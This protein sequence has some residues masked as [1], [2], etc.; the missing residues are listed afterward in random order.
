MK[1]EAEATPPGGDDPLRRFSALSGDWFWVQ[2]AR[3]RL[4][5]LSSN[6]GDDLGVDLSA[7]LGAKRWAKAIHSQFATIPVSEREAEAVPDPYSVNKMF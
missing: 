7:Y 3:L 2:D 4:T 5:Y 6:L 1:E